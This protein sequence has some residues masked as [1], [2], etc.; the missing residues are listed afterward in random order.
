MIVISNKKKKFLE[1]LGLDIN[2]LPPEFEK[3]SHT[4]EEIFSEEEIEFI[5]YENLTEKNFKKFSLKNLVG[6]THPS[7]CN[8]TWL[9]AFLSSKRGDNAVD[10]YFNNPEYYSHDLKQLDQSNLKHDTPIELYESNNK[11]F[12]N[13][14][15][16]RLSLI[17]MKYLSELSNASTDEERVKI[18]EEYTFV[19]KVQATP[20][21][22]DIMYMLNMI[23]ENYGQYSYIS[24]LSADE[25]SCEYAIHVYNNIIKINNKE[26][27]KQA[28]KN[29]YHLNKVDSL[30]K[31]KDHI[32]HLIQDEIIYSMRKDQNRSRILNEVFPNLQQFKESFSALKHYGIENKLYEGID[33]QNINFSQLSDKAIKLAEIEK[34]RK[35]KEQNRHAEEET[36]KKDSTIRSNHEN[37]IHSKIDMTS[38]LKRGNIENKTQII[39]SNIEKL[40]YELKNEELKF[41]RIAKQLGLDYLL[42]STDDDSIYSNIND[43]KNNMQQISEKFQQIDNPEEL[44][45]VSE[46]LKELENLSQNRTIKTE[47]TIELKEKFEKSFDSKIYNLIKDSKLSRLK[48][49]R[50]QIESEK[51]SLIGKMLGK[52]KLKQAKLTNINLKIQLLN[53]EIRK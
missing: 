6:T 26:E 23:R 14:G 29:S 10:E 22:K 46:I 35:T 28:L 18:D 48:Q 53:S 41:R 19:A 37:G 13:G 9:E 45:K 8:K 3:Y 52:S 31:L 36:I 40:Y 1:S 11:F 32:V 50:T 5:I 47:Y 43:I 42:T 24:K 17:M 39:P 49:E 2:N 33:L 12:I 7:Y 30:N 20:K 38:E 44:D 34:T 4:M 25:Q 51:I 16:N 15:N 21:D 27:L